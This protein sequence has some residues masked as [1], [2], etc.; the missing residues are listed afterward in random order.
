MAKGGAFEREIS[1][2]LSAWWLSN[3]DADTSD[4]I[5][6]RT[7]Q[8]GGRA[9]TR[10]K[11][12]RKTT[13]AHCGDIAS[14]DERGAP[15]TQ[16]ITF[17][18]KK[19]YSSASLHALLDKPKSAAVQIYEKWIAQAEASAKA[20]GSQYWAIIHSRPRRET[21]ITM[22]ADLLDSL[23]NDVQLPV[24]RFGTE[25]VRDGPRTDIKW[26]VSCLF[27]EFLLGVEPQDIRLLLMLSKK[28]ECV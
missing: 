26:C 3:P 15:L 18:L 19:G 4:V 2:R 9:T 27:D 17:E 16:L 10:A 12:G 13:T 11:T 7:S 24:I 14:L 8:S 6:W 21:T 22:P 23:H 25:P 5:F 20:A 1:R 28:R